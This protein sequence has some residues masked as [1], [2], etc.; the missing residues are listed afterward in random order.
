MR[1]SQVILK[2]VVRGKIRSLLTCLGVALAVATMVTLVGFSSGLE[3]STTEV[4]AARNIDLVV[5]RAGVTQRLTSNLNESLAE[6]LAILPHVKQ[7]GPSLTDM[8]SF[9]NGSLVGIPVHGWPAGGFAIETLTMNRGRKL[10]AADHWGVLLG[11]GLARALNKGIDDEVDIEQQQFHIVGIYAG[12][13]V[14]ENMTAVVLLPDLQQLMDRAG[15]VTEFQIVFDRETVTD[16]QAIP[17]LRREIEALRDEQ[18]HRF[19]LAAQSTQQYVAGSTEIGMARAMAWGTSAIA[20]VIGCVGVLNTMMM[21]V[22][23][24]TQEIG[25]LRALGWRTSRIMRMIVGETLTISAGG[26]VAGVAIGVALTRLLSST[27]WLVGLLQPDVSPTVIGASA[28]SALGIGLIGGG[29]PAFRAAGLSAVEAL[30]Y[31]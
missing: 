11:E 6:R 2:N 27:P 28:L 5:T 19:G 17:Q 21:S 18:G 22:L 4:Y 13:N 15:Q 12:L 14:Y 9:W 7:V 1:F 29:Y 16:P 10:T 31:E 23:E 30:H 20:L 8:V 24:R 25:I 26:I 3:N